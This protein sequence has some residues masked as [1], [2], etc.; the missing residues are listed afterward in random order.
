[1]SLAVTSRKYD[2]FYF[3]LKLTQILL[4]NSAIWAGIIYAKTVRR[5]K[6]AN[7]CT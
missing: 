2:P 7:W 6:V 4:P 1:M 5:L 3:R